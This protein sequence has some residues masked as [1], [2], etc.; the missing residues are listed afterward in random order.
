MC[1]KVLEKIQAYIVMFQPYQE[2]SFDVCH[3]FIVVSSSYFQKLD[4]L[5]E[6]EKSYLL[7]LVEQPSLFMCCDEHGSAYL[8]APPYNSADMPDDYKNIIREMFY[9]FPSDNNNY[10]LKQAKRWFQ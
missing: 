9:D 8:L 7:K 5:S 10:A 3:V 6:N 4:V 1:P 2:P